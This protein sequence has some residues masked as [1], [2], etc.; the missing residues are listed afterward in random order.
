[1]Q[2][3]PRLYDA[4]FEHDSCGFGLVAQI[5]G[6]ASAWVVD[7]AFSALAKLSHRGAVNADGI[8]G[9]GCGV[10]L[11]R[12]HD[13][14]R[15]LAADSGIAL[16]ER[17]AAGVVFLDPA[18]GEKAAQVL[19]RHLTEE[20]VHVAGWRDVAV[21]AEA[22]GPLAAAAQPR[23]RQIFV[24][25]GAA[26]DDEVFELALFRA[27]RRAETALT[28]DPQF[29]VV[30]LS[31]AVIGYKAMAAPGRLREVFADLSHPALAADAVVFHQRFSTNTTPQWRLAQPFRLLAHN[32]E[33]NTIRANRRWMQARESIMRSPRVDLSDIG[34]LVR[35]QGSDSESLDNALEILL[36]GGLDLLAAMRV[37]VPPA[38]AARENI[39][40]D[41]AAFYEYYALHSEPWDGPAGLVMCDGRYAACTLDRNGLRPARWALSDDNHL[42]V[43]SEAGLWD[44]PS[45]RVIAKGRLAPGEM[46][47]VDFTQHRLLRDADID[48][49]NRTRAPYRDWLRA[50]VSYLESDLIDP[51]LAAEPLPADELHCYQKLYGLSR[52]ERETVLKVIAELEAE[53][54]GSMGD[55]TPV[56][57]MSRQVRPLFDRFRQ[58]FAQVTNP[59]IDPL[60]EK[61]VM[62]LV[63]QIGPEG[64]VFE[65]KAENAKQV[66][67]NSPILSQRKLRQLLA[68]PQ[69]VGTPRFDLMYS[70][71]EQNL[72][73]ALRALC[74]QVAQAVRRGCALVFLSDR[75][76]QREQ[77]PIHALLATG[78]VHAH[79][80]DRGLRCQCNIIVET[81]T[82]RDPHQFACF[83]GFGATAIYPWLAYQS[84]FELGREGHIDGDRVEIGR[85]YRRGIRKGLLKILSKMGISTIAGYRGAQLFEIVG[86]AP[87]VVSMCFPSTPSR[88][89]GAGFAELEHEQRLLAA[90]AWNQ[91]LPLRAGGLYKF[92]YGGE[93]HMYNP[94]VIATLQLAV[95]TGNP[96]DYRVYADHVDHRPPSALRDLLGLKPASAPIA[97]EEVEPI[98]AILKRFDSAGMSLGALSPEAHEALAIG[99]NRLGGRSNSGEGG[100]DPARYGTEKMSKIKQVASGRFGVTPAYLVNAEVLQ[101][102]IAQG[103]KPGEGGQLPGHKVDATIARLRYAKPGIGLISPPPHHDIYSIEDLA[104]LIHDLKEVNPSA[105]ISVK[106]VSHAGVGTVAAG[107]V[108]A[109]ADLI[110]VS[111][112]DGGTGASPLTSIKYAGTPWELGVAETQQTL[113]RNDLRGRVRLQT[114]GGLKTGLD[115]IKAALLGAESFGFG[116][117]PMVALGCKYLRICHLNNCATGV[118]TQHPVLR[119]EHFIGLP[120]MVMNYFRFVAED[121]RAHLAQLGVRSLGEIVGRTELL[122]QTAGTTPVQHKLDLSPLI[123]GT[124]LSASSDFACTLARNPVRDDAALASRIAVDTAPLVELGESGHFNYAIANTDRAIGA[125]LSGA[126][127]RRHGDHGMDEHPICLKLEGA[128]GQSLGAW[129]AGGL[130]I[131]LTGEANDGVG[132]G[133]AGGRIVVRPPLD[134]PYASQDAAIVGNTCL[135][136][137]TGGELFAAGRAGERFAVRNSGAMA[138]VEG[139]GDHCCEYMTGGVVAVLGK[140]GLNFGAGM[141]GGFAYVLDLERDF[142]DCYNHELVDIL[143]ISPEGMENYM[144]HLR[145]L[146]TRHAELTGS[147][148]G[149]QILNDFRGLQYKFW[150]VKPKAA[151]LAALA[152]ELRVAA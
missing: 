120:E 149:R 141:T 29:Y 31:A 110:T 51:T 108:K 91:A 136:G 7:T 116:T 128:A 24:D 42:I 8:S 135:Y 101:I 18:G 76:P 59:P 98:E 129:N 14:L 62:S 5:D 44:V 32:G 94:D 95:R 12:P 34:P 138:V 131:D 88:I 9:D 23:V 3:A 84:L 41:L 130:H 106:L 2:V 80:I 54:T 63:T 28:D 133:M 39:D 56:A 99:M 65:L 104:Q 66:L 13:W 123:D 124:G 132:K 111:G 121:V 146:V 93:Y 142:V 125:R 78:A 107:V 45:A 92:V 47:A 83:V 10:L 25:A 79:L 22:C 115:V 113:R 143:R 1:M 46:I 114:D 27:R 11:H 148:W 82:P 21:N 109:G 16:A 43:A 144:Q 57:A 112:H 72:E 70:P 58:G 75:Y 60:R 52:E 48:E 87:E 38:F 81:A 68:L 126:I 53:A 73:S 55:D 67:I 69:F 17:F 40:E 119:K 64:N 150:L 127:A 36:A 61:L 74:E 118:A 49:I 77:L 33:I 96:A 20:G 147:A 15:A 117:G 50:G 145:R 105:L 37:L 35:Q 102:K 140:V 19:E 100:E 71:S 90:E 6:R 139:A 152:E 103:A 26:M 30:T 86:L 89:G 122:E 97:L 134:A 137:A 4:S 85:S 151:S